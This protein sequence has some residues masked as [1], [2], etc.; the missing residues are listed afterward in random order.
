MSLAE[1]ALIVQICSLSHSIISS[2]VDWPEAIFITKSYFSSR[3]VIPSLRQL[4][5]FYT[6]TKV[7]QISVIILVFLFLILPFGK[8]SW[9]K[10]F[11]VYP[12]SA[13]ITL[14]A[15]FWTFQRIFKFWKLKTINSEK[16]LQTLQQLIVSSCLK[17]QVN[18]LS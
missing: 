4:N 11:I 17:I 6:W 2:K 18:P 16:I 1:F 3:V 7:G 15:L 12:L 8:K 14:I 9:Y 13:I 10:N 5:I